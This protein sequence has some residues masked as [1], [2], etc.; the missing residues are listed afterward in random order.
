MIPT[1]SLETIALAM[2]FLSVVAQSLRFEIRSGLTKCI[3]EDMRSNAMT[4]GKFSVVNPSDP[5]PLDDSHKLNLRVH[6]HNSPTS[7]EDDC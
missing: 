1:R 2:V 4:V 5:L 3:S 7:T 6:D